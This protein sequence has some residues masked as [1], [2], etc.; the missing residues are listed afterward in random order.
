MIF[1]MKESV[2][3]GKK[4]FRKRFK[5]YLDNFYKELSEY[6][7]DPN[8]ENIHDI[9]TSIRR[10]EAVYRIAP[11]NIRKI[12]QIKNYVNLAK[13]LFKFNAKIR[14]LDITCKKFETRYPNNTKSLVLNLKNSRVEL[15]QKANKLALEIYRENIPKIPKLDL[16]GSKLKKRYDEVL[17]EVE[18][19][20]QKNT[21]IVLEDEGKLEELH[22]LR[23]DFKKL[24]YSIELISKESP[25]IKK[26]KNFQDALGEIHDC[27]IIID[28]LK[29][30]GQDPNYNEI[31]EAENL[32][33]GKKYQEF[34]TLL[35][36]KDAKS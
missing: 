34:V 24:R 36:S 1:Q 16:K 31:I 33:R 14:D 32:E 21:I 2:Y 23:K 9:R 13:K 28:C 10:L 3:F 11:K 5:K 26:L 6:I 27:D 17:D 15:I 19:Q 25:G 22:M 29:R 7:S 12:K 20:I 30:L 35:K 18:F 4:L 8:E